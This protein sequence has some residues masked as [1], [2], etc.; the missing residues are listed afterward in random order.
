MLAGSSSAGGGISP[1][2]VPQRSMALV[3]A[4]ERLAAAETLDDV[5]AIVR[6]AARAISGA[7]GVTFVLMDEDRCH[8]VDEDAISPLWKGKRFPLTSCI[9]GW[10]MLHDEKAVIPDIYVDSRIPHDA[11]RPTFVKS[12][13]MVPVKTSKPV[14][15]IGSYWSEQRSF[16]P[17][18][19][20][21]LEALARSTAAALTVIQTRE[22]LRES[23]ARL[24]MALTA[25]GLGTW[26][27][28]LKTEA[29]IASNEARAAF[30]FASDL[31]L[32]QGVIRAAIHPDD[33]HTVR[34][35]IATAIHDGIDI[36]IELRNV[37]PD[38]S[39]RWITARGRA[40]RDTNGEPVRVSGVCGDVSYRY[41]AKER[42]DQLQ[43]DIA[44]I[45]RLTEMGQM[46]SAFAH[47]LRQPLTAANNYLSAAK[48]F[49]AQENVPIAR[50]NELIGKADGQFR[51]ATEII[52]RIR[53]F[54]GKNNSEAAPENLN[55]LIREAVELARVDP[56]H[57]GVSVRLDI[58]K[59]LPRVVVDKVQIQQVLLNLLRNAFEAME[60]QK[61]RM[62]SVRAR[63]RKD[64]K[65]AEI[66]V[67]DTGPG[68]APEVLE[69]LFQPFVTTKSSGMGVGLSICRTIVESH[70]GQMWAE[71]EPDAG[72]TFLIT[73]PAAP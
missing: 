28:D 72:A 12:L 49:L 32:T 60:T 18:E 64:G 63:L 16:E 59:S 35:T 37:R 21:L 5:I 27:L 15:A 38:G 17:E 51:R 20:A 55:A 67:S 14:A 53:G 40:I 54:S 47:E 29:I 45:G 3:S 9:S 48:R 31:S 23:E 61:V 44:H 11:Y 41:E 33:Y 10:C 68:L 46:V 7:D 52:Q 2:T 58:P 22:H 56:R 50:I 6:G 36:R 19:V 42:M 26:E 39:I 8:Y 70:G 25:G 43:A 65:C 24:N 34:Q 62:I 69:K 71:S 30:G 73:L 4:V 57:H 13:I 1:A 66:S